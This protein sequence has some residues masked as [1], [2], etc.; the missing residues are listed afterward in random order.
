M[1][2]VLDSARF[3]LFLSEEFIV[4]VEDVT[5]FVLAATAIR[6]FRLPVTPRL[7]ACL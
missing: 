6:W 2:G 7:P 1:A 3:R 4:S 5:A